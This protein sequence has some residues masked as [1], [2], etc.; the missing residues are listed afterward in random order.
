MMKALISFLVAALCISYVSAQSTTTATSTTS[1][2]QACNC[3]TYVD[4]GTAPYGNTTKADGSC[5][6]CD[7]TTCDQSDLTVCTCPTESTCDFAGS[8]GAAVAALATYLIV[9]IVVASLC[10]VCCIVAIIICVCGGTA[11]LCVC[12][13]EA[14]KPGP[15][16]GGNTQM[17]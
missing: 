4:S 1:T 7:L 10:G 2:T 5:A 6:Y 16:Q 17:V 8:I 12:C 9:V 13:N 14:S 11:A 15:N 3:Q